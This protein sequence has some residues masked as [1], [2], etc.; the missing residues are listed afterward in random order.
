MNEIRSLWC[1]RFR[2]ANR[3]ETECQ[4]RW[5]TM[6]NRARQFGAVVIYRVRLVMAVLG[7]FDVVAILM[8]REAAFK[9]PRN[10]GIQDCH[11][12]GDKAYGFDSNPNGTWYSK[13]H[14]CRLPSCNATDSPDGRTHISLRLHPT[15]ASSSHCNTIGFLPKQPLPV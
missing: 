9:T 13:R 12:Q 8:M 2:C 6:N 7:Q 3:G 1:K 5:R 10:R 11:R 14:S 4:H 15:D